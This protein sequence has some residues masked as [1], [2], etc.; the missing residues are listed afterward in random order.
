M[1]YWKEGDK[2]NNGK[3]TVEQI[4]GCGGFGVTYKIRQNKNNRLF[5]L[6][7]LNLEARAKPDFPQL[8]A[9]FINE[10][11]ALASC[12][13]PNI[14]RVYPQGFQEGNLWCMVMEYVEGEDLSCYLDRHGKLEEAQAIE[15]ITK[16][17][18]ALHFVHQQELLHRDIKPANILLRNSNSQPVLIDFGLAREYTHGQSII[19]M[20]NSRTLSFAPPEQFQERGNFGA[21]TDVYALAAT[22]YVL[23]TNELPL[24]A[25]FRPHADLK[26]P[27]EFNSNTSDRLNEAILKGMAMEISDRPQSIEKWLELLKP[28]AKI[29]VLNIQKKEKLIG[30]RYQLI[31]SVEVERYLPGIYTEHIQTFIASDTKLDCHCIVKRIEFKDI[32]F[33]SNKHK[34]KMFVWFKLTSKKYKE[35]N[36]KQ[37]QSL[38]DY[39]WEKDYFYWIYECIEGHNIGKTEIARDKIWQESDL[40]VFLIELLEILVLFEDKTT[41][42]SFHKIYPSNLIRRN[43]DKKVVIDE[44]LSYEINKL[45]YDINIPFDYIEDCLYYQAYT[46]YEAPEIIH[47]K[48]RRLRRNSDIYSLGMVA[49]QALTGLDDINLYSHYEDINL[50]DKAPRCSDELA[51]I[52]NKMVKKNFKERYQSASEVIKDLTEVKTA[53]QYLSTNQ[54]E[55]ENSEA[56]VI[57]G[58]SASINSIA[59]GLGGRILASGSSDGSVKLWNTSD[60][61]E[62]TTFKDTSQT[63]INSITYS[64]D[65][66]VLAI[67]KSIEHTGSSDNT[68][69]LWYIPDEQQSVT[70]IQIAKFENGSDRVLSLAFSPDGKIFAAGSIETIKL[71]NISSQQ[72]ITTLKPSIGF[73]GTGIVDSLAFNPN[74]RLLANSMKSNLHLWD[75]NNRKEITRREKINSLKHPSEVIS[76]TFSPN[77]QVLASISGNCI[78][79]WDMIAKEVYVIENNYSSFVS[80]IAFSPDGKTIAASN[81]TPVTGSGYTYSLCLWNVKTKEEIIIPNRFDNNFS[82]VAFSPDG[83]FLAGGTRDGKIRLWKVST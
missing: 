17:G 29:N 81:K 2:L 75:L 23:L 3:Y 36:Y 35:I 27:Q 44:C 54:S 53:N 52:V 41:F 68:I 77:G 78:K 73:F 12:R 42:I 45:I 13:H 64:H 47:S 51:R 24:P 32:L 22:L 8:Q 20:S 6:K 55:W 72:E 15:I 83:Q 49:V 1:R 67:S 31:D 59:F 34:Q 7:T 28:S 61:Q 58:H 70:L 74:G 62:I 79:L 11:I 76:V 9:K 80:P 18:E 40:I 57:Y 60:R 43:A 56:F 25:L 37:V 33:Y 82:S 16:V 48:N 21:W 10:A 4:L 38:Q 50:Q 5:A 66:K 71:W 14:V 63:R 26:P 30:D 19:S 39:F 65:G 46:P 69:E